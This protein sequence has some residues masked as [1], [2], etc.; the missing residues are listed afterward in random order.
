MSP[1]IQ[2]RISV[3]SG[4]HLIRLR[5]LGSG[6]FGKSAEQFWQKDGKAPG[7]VLACCTGAL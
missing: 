4:N 7:M 5:G 1:Q 3:R 2:N 6:G